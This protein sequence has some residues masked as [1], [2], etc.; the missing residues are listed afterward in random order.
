MY[1]A[2][3][4]LTGVAYP[5]IVTVVAQ[6][7]FP[8][9]SNGSLISKAGKFVGSRLV[10]QSFDAPK[11]FWGRPS[12][13]S[14]FPYNAAASGGSN[15]APTNPALIGGKDANGSVVPGVISTRISAL[16]AFETG[17]V[18]VPTDLATAS[19]SG[20]D[21]HISPG[22]AEYQVE[23][24]ARAR[25]MSAD[26]V[27]AIVRAHTEPPQLGVLGEPVVNVLELNLALDGRQ[28]E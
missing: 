6:L 23:R 3:T 22:A 4:V 8:E 13:T 17:T 26:A 11:Y 21:P 1:V 27:R 10:G 14:P 9:Q 2:L 12:F 20:L 19:A 25:R 15:L 7:P 5:A 28:G 24:V 16:R 18:Q